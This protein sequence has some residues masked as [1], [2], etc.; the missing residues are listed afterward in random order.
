[1]RPAAARLRERAR[2]GGGKRTEFVLSRRAAADDSL[3]LVE[4]CSVDVEITAVQAQDA[5]RLNALFELYAYDFSEILGMDVGDDGRFA[6]PP[7]DAH[8]HDPQRHAFLFRVGGKL[9]GF[10]LVEERCRLLR[11]EGANDVS[12]FFV[13]RRYRR[14]GVGQR[15]AA[16]LFDRFPGRWQV[17]EKAENVGATAFWRRAI[18]AYTGGRFDEIVLDDAR[19]HGPVQRFDSRTAAA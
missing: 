4:R 15:A 1:L 19:W 6:V 2:L 5:Q 10:A 8:V 13:M 12:E 16:W 3:T 11:D 9:A 14:L 17:R 7:I 18:G